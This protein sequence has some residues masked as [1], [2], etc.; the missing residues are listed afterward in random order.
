MDE[1]DRQLFVIGSDIINTVDIKTLNATCEALVEA[2]I[3]HAPYEEFDIQITASSHKLLSLQASALILKNNPKDLI[4]EDFMMTDF[5]R[6]Q[7]RPA[8]HEY[9]FEYCYL[10]KDRK[11]GNFIDENEIYDNSIIDGFDDTRANAV[12]S[13][14]DK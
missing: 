8:S 13:Y 11:T 14:M 2:G 1:R 6:Y 4:G 3:W 10:Y 9:N 5:Y 7:T 12:V